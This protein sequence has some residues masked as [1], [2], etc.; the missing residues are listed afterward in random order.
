MISWL[1]ATAIQGAIVGAVASSFVSVMQDEKEIVCTEEKVE[2]AKTHDVEL[3]GKCVAAIAKA[4]AR[5]EAKK[6][7][8]D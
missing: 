2:W 3:Y 7:R 4:E 8:N 1:I 6:K 5:A